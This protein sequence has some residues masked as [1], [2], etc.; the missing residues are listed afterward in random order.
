M[1]GITIQ[2]GME[3]VDEESADFEEWFNRHEIEEL[4]G[5]LVQRARAASRAELD[6]YYADHP[7]IDEKSRREINSAVDRVVN[8]IMHQPIETLKAEASARHPADFAR[9][10]RSIGQLDENA[11]LLSRLVFFDADGLDDAE[12]GLDRLHAELGD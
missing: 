5:S 4:I 6:R 2:I 12:A 9:I 3:M 8:Q 11:D 7:D 1:L 10:V